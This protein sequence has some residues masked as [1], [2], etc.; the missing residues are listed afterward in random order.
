MDKLRAL[1]EEK[2]KSTDLSDI[3]KVAV[4]EPLLSDEA[5][6]FKIDSN[7]AVGI[8]KYLGI[9]DDQIRQKYFE[10]ISPTSYKKAF[11][12]ERILHIISENR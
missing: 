5:C 6:F 7:T 2:K 10:L 4:L 1:L 11:P 9:P 3:E 12:K 8:F